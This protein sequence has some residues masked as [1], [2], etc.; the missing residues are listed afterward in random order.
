MIRT[1][2]RSSAVLAIAIL[3]AVLAAPATASAAPTTASAEPAASSDGDVQPAMYIDCGIYPE[4]NPAVTGRI[5]VR[6]RTTSRGTMQVRAGY[7]NGKQYGWARALNGSYH[8]WINLKIDVNGDRVAD[9][10][11]ISRATASSTCMAPTSSSS[12][13]AFKACIRLD[14]LADPCHPDHQTGWW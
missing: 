4:T 14:N 3:G 6:E 13:V 5:T 7:Y 9:Q 12:A 11:S 10:S 1:I 2:R 8:H